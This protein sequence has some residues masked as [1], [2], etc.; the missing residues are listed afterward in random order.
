MAIGLF[1]AKWGGM[2]QGKGTVSQI[3]G[4]G[5]VEMSHH[6]QNNLGIRKQDGHLQLLKVRHSRTSVLS[7]PLALFSPA[8]TFPKHLIL[9]N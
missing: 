9:P 5:K 7:F 6:S 3:H 1:F 2:L 8:A 4:A